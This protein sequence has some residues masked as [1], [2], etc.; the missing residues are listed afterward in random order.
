MN[1]SPTCFGYIDDEE[2]LALIFQG[3]LNGDLKCIE[4]RPYEAEKAGLVSSGNIFVFNEE[5]S[6]IKRW[7]DGFSWSPSR[8]SGKFLVYREYNRLVSFQDPSLHN[9]LDYNIFKRAHREYFYTGLLKKTFSLKFNIDPTETNKLET[10]HLIAYYAEKDIDQGSLKRPSENPFFQKF[11]PSQELSDALQKV[12]VGNGRS[13]PSRNNERDRAKA[14]NS[15]MSSSLSPSSSYSHHSN[16]DTSSPG[17]IPNRASFNN[18]SNVQIPLKTLH[19]ISGNM[20]TQQPQYILPIEQQNQLPFPYVQHQP[21]PIG[22]Y[23]PSYEPGLKRTVS[24]PVIF[25]NTYN[26]LPQQPIS[27]PH[28][29]RSVTPPMVYLPNEI[30][31]RPYQNIN[32]YYSRSGLE[33]NNLNAPIPSNMVP[34]VHSILMHDYRQQKLP[35]NSNPAQPHN[36]TIAPSIGN[37]DLDGMYILPAPRI[38]PPSHTQYQMTFAP[39]SM[40]HPSSFNRNNTPTDHIYHQNSK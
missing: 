19:N 16:K 25:C 9:I 1:I 22:I 21:Q 26:T 10:F 32:L 4:R 39:N 15:R 40:Q 13:N 38:N 35:T 36:A 3:V 5:K 34:P 7:T 27:S 29:G 33:S 8:I 12:A 23:N 30:N 2:D 20:H 14:H 24:Q 17:N 11:C 18:E 37:K 28:G 6:G 31:A